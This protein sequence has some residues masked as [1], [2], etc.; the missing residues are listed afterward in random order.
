MANYVCRRSDKTRAATPNA[1]T[2]ISTVAIPECVTTALEKTRF[3]LARISGR[4]GSSDIWFPRCATNAFK[5]R[6]SS[7]TAD[8]SFAGAE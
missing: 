7:A 4:L 3:F 2:A 8:V 1:A 5:R 6:T